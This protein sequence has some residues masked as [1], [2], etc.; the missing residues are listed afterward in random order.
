MSKTKKDNKEI[1][2]AQIKIKFS[3]FDLAI[4]GTVRTISLKCGKPSC[5]CWTKKSARHGPYYF[6]D[7]KV[8]GKLSSKSIAKPM[9][10]L[11]RKWIDNR[12]RIE[13]LFQE[14][15]ELSQA[16]AADMIEKKKTR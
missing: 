15:L 12:R 14:V 13:K 2:L 4:P 16:I 8:D 3:E 9:V 10:P 11:L 5:T 6:W 1:K 7:R